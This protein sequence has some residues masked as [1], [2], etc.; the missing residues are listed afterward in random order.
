VVVLPDM[1]FL[2]AIHE[3]RL[4]QSA[5]PAPDLQHVRERMQQQQPQKQQEEEGH[6][7]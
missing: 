7:Q 3:T 6:W 5:W 2:D 1:H 4:A